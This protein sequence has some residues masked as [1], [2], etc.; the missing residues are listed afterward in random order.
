MEQNKNN[1]VETGKRWAKMVAIF[2]AITI[3]IRLTF[4]LTANPINID[5]V[6]ALLVG[7]IIWAVVVCAIV[8]GIG[9]L[10]ASKDKK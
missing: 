6:A 8:F 1:K 10:I 3:L 5:S 9:Y 7:G 4:L 2:F